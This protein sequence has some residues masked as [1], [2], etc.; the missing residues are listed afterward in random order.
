MQRHV[1]VIC[2]MKVYA[3]FVDAAECRRSSGVDKSL[4]NL[5][6]IREQVGMELEGFDKNSVQF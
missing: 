6:G 3:L 4:E 2:R 1:V 5:Q